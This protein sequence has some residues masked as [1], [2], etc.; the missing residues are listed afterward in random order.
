MSPEVLVGLAAIVLLAYVVQT[1][2]G[3]GST[4]VALTFGALLLPIGELLPL[5]VPLSFLQT[6][7][8]ATRYR[9]QIAWGLLLR[10]VLPVMGAGLLVGMYLFRGFAGPWMRAAFGAM[11]LVL[12]LRELWTL[13][14][15]DRTGRGALSLPASVAAIFGAGVTHGIYGTGGPLLVYA[16]GREGLDKHRFRAT[17]AA[18]WITLNSVLVVGFAL[19]GAYDAAQLG[20]AGLLLLAVPLGVGLGEA[21]HRRVDERRF[22]IGVFSLLV[23]AALSLLLK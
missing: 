1:A 8:I 23:V 13:L 20:H 10:R 11:V 21:V 3:F 16:T 4:L 18:V 14:G 22:K 19:D 7:Y 15:A 5:I 2:A 12:A 17:L 6:G 9:E